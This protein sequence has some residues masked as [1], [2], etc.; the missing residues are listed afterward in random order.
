[1]PP[2]G[3]AQAKVRGLG[4][5]GGH[6]LIREWRCRGTPIR[7]CLGRERLRDAKKQVKRRGRSG[8]RVVHESAE[9]QNAARIVTR[10]EITK[11]VAMASWRDA[12]MPG[13]ALRYGAPLPRQYS[14]LQQDANAR[15][16]DDDVEGAV[17]VHTCT[18][19]S[20]CH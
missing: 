12:E 20:R 9:A 14:G 13:C 6:D 3:V 7:T 1:M 19:R 17:I 18:A 15:D 4:N 2:G 16:G 11:T 8:G 10:R 5:R